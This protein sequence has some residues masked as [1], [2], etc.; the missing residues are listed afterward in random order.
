ML[1]NTI[2]TASLVLLLAR[3]GAAAAAEAS[4]KTPT[5][6]DFLRAMDKARKNVGRRL[7]E[8]DFKRE[9][10]GNS[11]QS[12]ELRKKIMKKSVVTKAPGSGNSDEGRKLQNN[13]N[14]QSNYMYDADH[15]GT[16]DWLNTYGAWENKFGFDVTQYSASYHRCAEVKQFDDE[17][18]AQEDTTSVFATKHFAVFR[19]CPENTCMG[20]VEQEADCGCS[21][22]CAAAIEA[23]GGEANGGD[24]DD[25]DECEASCATQC[26]I[27]QQ[28][29]SMYDSSGNQ[30][31]LQNNNNNNG[32]SSWDNFAFDAYYDDG[33]DETVYG[34]RGEGCQSNYG[35]YMIEV[36]EYLEI[37]LEWQYKRYEEYETY[38]QTCMY[39]VYQQWLK[40][41]GGRHLSFEDFKASEEHRNLGGYYGACPEYD[42]CAEYQKIKFVDKWSGY[43]ECSEVEKANGQIAYVGPHCAEDGFTITLGVYSDEN[44]YDYIGNGIDISAF[45]INVG[46]DALKSYYNSAMGA[47]F[48]QL[49][50]VEE[51]TVCIPC[52]S[53]VSFVRVRFELFI[54]PT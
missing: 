23:N 36:K 28:Q 5:M 13:Y 54:F 30:R 53:E 21:Y 42:T 25:E 45:G 19:L 6:T 9:V 17:L 52:N 35:E 3:D 34:A 26:A 2:A 20:F 48:E 4:P 14:Y 43:F 11:K 22:Q 18:A 50:Y 41:G 12:A 47:T 49:K 51:D 8:S 38:C 44:C 7:S 31:K 27:W 37:M 29:Y 15:D 16:D 32:G 24:E 10:Y 33:S 1:S 39:K 46:D 40:N